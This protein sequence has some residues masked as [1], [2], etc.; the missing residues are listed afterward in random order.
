MKIYTDNS[1]KILLAIV[2]LCIISAGIYLIMVLDGRSLSAQTGKISIS[3]YYA[4]K[5][6]AIAFRNKHLQM[7]VSDFPSDAVFR[8]VLYQ[9]VEEFECEYGIHPINGLDEVRGRAVIV[10]GFWVS[11]PESGALI[12]ERPFLFMNANDPDMT[13][14][15]T[16]KPTE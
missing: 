12:K 16:I 8:V 9:S 5:V 6:V 11:G 10:F 13:Y 1:A 2:V 14:I 3:S 15:I 4:H 7:S